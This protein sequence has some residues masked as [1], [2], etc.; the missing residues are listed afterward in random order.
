M[1]RK[2]PA[3]ILFER[4]IR[5]WVLP[6]VRKRTEK[7]S[8]TGSV[9]LRLVLLVWETSNGPTV[10]VNDEVFG[11]VES[12][13]IIA[14]RPIHKGQG[15]IA[16]DVAGID[17]I[18]LNKNYWGKSYI[19]ICQGKNDSYYLVFGKLGALKDG[20]DFKVLKKH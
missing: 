16:E 20:D 14:S 13:K 4:V 2:S 10:Y 11:K 1:S 8:Q 19:F 18:K 15:V 7:S 17:N 3:Q 5:T 6:Y 9:P 12:V